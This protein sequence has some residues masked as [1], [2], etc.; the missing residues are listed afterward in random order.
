MLPERSNLLLRNAYVLPFDPDI[1]ERESDVLIRDGVIEDIDHGID[2]PDG[3]DVVDAT[4]SL[5]LPGF[6]D[7]HW[8]L[9]NSLLRGT[10]GDAP[11]RDYFSVK[12]GLAPHFNVDDFY[13]SARFALA[14]AVQNGIT[15]IHNWDHN[16]VDADDVDANLQAQ[17]DA[18]LRGRFSYGPRDSSPANEEMVFSGLDAARERWSTSRLDD[19][20]HFGV[21]LRGP[22]RTSTELSG[23]EWQEARERGMPITMHCDRCMREADCQSCG[24][25]RLEQEGLLGSDVQIVHAVHASPED[26]EAI[27]RTGTKIS[28]S[29]LSEMR[30]MGFPRITEFLEADV[31]TSVSIDTLAMPANADILSTLR[32]LVSAEHARTG[33]ATLTPRIALE[34]ATI[35]AA[36]DLGIDHITGSLRPGKRADL[37]LLD[38]AHTSMLPSGDVTESLVYH[39][40]SAAIHTVI[41]DGRILLRDRALVQESAQHAID[42]VNQRRDALVDRARA[43]GT[44]SK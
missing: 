44:W 16:V 29:P 13:W 20:I 19:R 39:G 40:T 10:V 2:V 32:S 21:A 27:A 23:S 33:R 42:S 4:G 36:R 15:T 25:T 31:L 7:T 6:I 5:L 41:C 3:V 9:W 11:G 8:H 35:R 37:I 1:P 43:A 38:R 12:R 14:E 30:T 18:G 34:M 22:Y 17:L 24:L 26:I 28:V